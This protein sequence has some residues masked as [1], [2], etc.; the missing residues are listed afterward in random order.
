M[1]TATAYIILDKTNAT[2]PG[3]ITFDDNYANALRKTHRVHTIGT[4]TCDRITQQDG[5]IAIT[6]NNKTYANG[7]A[8][9]R[10]NNPINIDPKLGQHYTNAIHQHAQ[11]HNDQ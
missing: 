4:I 5:I 11:R 2:F 10:D 7:Y 6:L 9:L 1:Q 3:D 8:Y